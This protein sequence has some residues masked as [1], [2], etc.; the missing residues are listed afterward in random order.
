M[1]TA[2]RNRRRLLRFRS[3]RR[4][5][6]DSHDIG[7]FKNVVRRTLLVRLVLAGAAVA[8]LLAA[9]AAARNPETSEQALV[10][11]DR[12]GVVVLDL[13]LSIADEDY[14]AIRR[15][16]RRLIKE[17]A[18]IGLVVFSDA[19]YELLPPGTPAAELKPILR[20]LVAPRL[21]PVN[22]PWTQTF[23]AG[24]RISAALELARASLER[25]EIASGSILLVSDLE[26]APDDVPALATAI[27]NVEKAGTRLRVVPLGPSSD[28]LSLFAGLLPEDAFSGD[29]G[30]APDRREPEVGAVRTET[31]VI[32][33][34]LGMLLFVVLAV[35]E[36]LAG[37]LA[38]PRSR[39]QEG[40]TA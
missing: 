21:G 39:G 15:T 18:A 16:L 11:S 24:T 27:A 31:P 4:A 40:G 19:P 8:L 28:S 12:I 33:V 22:N 1:A 3:R 37:R 10:P 38:L 17:E 35:H 30:T 14:A 9:A 36:G 2:V 29:L 6:V 26:T 25:D 13:S 5:G 23:R 32:L 34:V 7:A 20:L